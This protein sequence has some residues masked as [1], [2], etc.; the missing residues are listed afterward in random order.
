ME[1]RLARVRA[2]DA[3]VVLSVSRR[4]GRTTAHCVWTLR[5]PRLHSPPEHINA[6]TG[7]SAALV[8][9]TYR[10]T[11]IFRWEDEQWKLIHRHADAMIDTQPP[12]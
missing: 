2:A 6:Q 1:Q 12:T 4:N 11:H 7:P 3:L 10:V 9:K 5:R 8:D